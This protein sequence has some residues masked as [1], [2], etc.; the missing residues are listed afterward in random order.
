MEKNHVQKACLGSRGGVLARVAAQ[1]SNFATWP[2]GV[3]SFSALSD[4]V[5]DLGG[6]LVYCGDAMPIR[7]R[8]VYLCESYVR[9]RISFQ[10]T[11]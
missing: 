4:F 5:P 1:P 6:L 8:V 11:F 2:L 7:L 10:P 3:T 9:P